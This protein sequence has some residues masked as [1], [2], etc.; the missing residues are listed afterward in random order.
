MSIASLTLKD[1]T[2]KT[3]ILSSYLLIT[4]L[5]PYFHAHPE[6]DHHEVKG[7]FYHSHAELFADHSHE[8]EHDDGNG[9]ERQDP[10]FHFLVGSYSALTE[11]LSTTTTECRTLCEYQTAVTSAIPQSTFA[12]QKCGSTDFEFLNLP[13]PQEQFFQFATDLSPPV[14]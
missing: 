11:Y 5:T 12:N 8:N 2:T 7:T 4:F 3:V 14:S 9:E 1:K 13:P 10:S 6:E